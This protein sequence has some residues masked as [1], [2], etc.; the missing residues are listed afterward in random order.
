MVDDR[1][2]ELESRLAFT[3]DNVEAL[4]AALA[5]QQQRIDQLERL[6]KE[7]LERIRGLSG[8]RQ[9]TLQEERPPHY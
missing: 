1:F 3:D 2:I 8:G 6:C 7:L 4:N 9:P 5:A